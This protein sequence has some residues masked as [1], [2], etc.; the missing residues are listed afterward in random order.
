MTPAEFK[1]ARSQLG[2]SAR[3]LA[4]A[5][6]L[7]AHGGRTVRRWESGDSPI[8]GPVAVLMRIW[9]WLHDGRGVPLKSSSRLERSG[10]RSA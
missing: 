9:L 8:S 5:L 3:A 6:E 1:A 7:G 10:T 4:E 2:L